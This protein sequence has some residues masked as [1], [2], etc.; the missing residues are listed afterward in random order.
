MNPF[1]LL[2]PPNLADALTLLSHNESNAR[3]MSGGTALM[4]MMKSGVFQPTQL[5]S[6]THLPELQGIAV[7]SVGELCIGAATSLR[8]L[9][10]SQWVQKHAPVISHAMKKLANVRVR[11]V[12]CIGGALAHGDPHMDL[13]PIL[14]CINANIDIVSAKGTRS[15]AVADLFRGYYETQLAE[16][17]IIQTVRIPSLA[18]RICHYLKCTTRSADDW[19]AVGIC[20]NLQVNA[21]VI[22]DAH[23]TLGSALEVPTRLGEVEK[24]LNGNQ[25]SDALFIEAG[26]LA[27]SM[28]TPMD[29]ALGSSLYKKQL[30]K[31]YLTRA[32]H[33]C[34]LEE[35]I[36]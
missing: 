12:A 21:N 31:I 27:A 3:P 4:L 1:E 15:I 10:H 25:V 23:I 16:G 24:R 11:N 32:L 34:M 7:N 5:I 35:S 8:D 30:V 20:V 22:H 13:P 18:G 17:E 26:Q 33:A 6:L 28:V 9:E 36:A 2:T 14:S 19:P 29:D